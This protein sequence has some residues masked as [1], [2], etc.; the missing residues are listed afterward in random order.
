MIYAGKTLILPT[1]QKKTQ[2]MTQQYQPVQPTIQAQAQAQ[3]QV[4]PTQQ[5]KSLL[6]LSLQELTSRQAE[7]LRMDIPEKDKSEYMD[8]LG[9]I[10]KT[11]QGMATQEEKERGSGKVCW[12]KW[13]KETKNK[14]LFKVESEEKDDYNNKERNS[15]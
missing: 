10:I 9:S 13:N 7:L 4:Q 12:E 1:I 3:T 11:K 15:L 8:F 2:P 14:K 6:D 5:P